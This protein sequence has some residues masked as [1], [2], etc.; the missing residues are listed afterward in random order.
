MR[1]IL[2]LAAITALG[3]CSTVSNTAARITPWGDDPNPAAERERAQTA[4]KTSAPITYRRA[5][6]APA[7]PTASSLP[8]AQPA[9]PSAGVSMFMLGGNV[10]PAPAQASRAEPSLEHMLG[11]SLRG[12]LP[13]N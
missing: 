9:P 5:S 8:P 4:P 6:V 10:A 2:A 7:A 3:G 13:E 1:S 11:G 12:R